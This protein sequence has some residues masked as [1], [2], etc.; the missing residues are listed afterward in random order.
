MKGKADATIKNHVAVLDP[1]P[2]TVRLY[3]DG[4]RRDGYNQASDQL[5][6]QQ[7]VIH[8]NSSFCGSLYQ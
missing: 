2:G 6:F 3:T 1:A 5:G 8:H 7:S 4:R